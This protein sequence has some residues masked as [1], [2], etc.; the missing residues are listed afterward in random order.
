MTEQEIKRLLLDIRSQLDRNGLR[1]DF[2]W[3][4]NGNLR[5]DMDAIKLTIEREEKIY[6]TLTIA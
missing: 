6:P 5:P 2:E 4:S 1:T 3:K